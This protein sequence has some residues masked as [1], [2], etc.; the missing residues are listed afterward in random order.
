MARMTHYKRTPLVGLVIAAVAL[1]LLAADPAGWPMWMVEV[2]LAAIG[3][4]LGTVLPVTTI[5]IQNAVAM[6][7]LGTATGCMNFFRS[8]GSAIVVAG[9][10]AI[11]LGA[12][13]GGP[14]QS[15]EN[16]GDLTPA[17]REGLVGAF[18]WLFLAAAVG[19]A[20]G[21]VWLLLM[22]ERPLRSGAAA[23]AKE[24]LVE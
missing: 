9:F 12:I 5:S 14:G 18:H 1:V 11:V 7:Q 24:A 13:G 20:L 8:L 10:G 4:G 3:L 22:E 19:L 15:A 2:L 17:M 21:F 6:H 23:H 16:L